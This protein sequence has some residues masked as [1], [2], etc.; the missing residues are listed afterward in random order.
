MDFTL[1][2][3]LK[4]S[5]E[6]IKNLESIKS[7]KQIKNYADKGCNWLFPE[8]C[9]ICKKTYQ[10][11]PSNCLCSTCHTQLLYLDQHCSLCGFA[12]PKHTDHCGRCLTQPPAYDH[13]FCAFQYQSVIRDLICQFKYSGRPELAKP[14]AALFM[15]EL[16]AKDIG[17][18]DLII[19]VPMH[20]NKLRQRGFNQSALLAKQLSKKMAIPYSDKIIKKHQHTPPQAELN[21]KQRLNNIKGS[22]VINKS[23]HAKNV[24]IIDD[25]VTT[26]ATMHEM[27]KILRKSGVNCIHVWGVAQTA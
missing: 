11:A 9:L 8:T 4:Y 20:L 18:P 14:L 25:V 10:N 24:A 5:L 17:L 2:K 3:H 15:H 22:F 7:L 12:L 26:G 6:R 16:H 27:T 1:N 19:P 21:H 23:L 13:Y